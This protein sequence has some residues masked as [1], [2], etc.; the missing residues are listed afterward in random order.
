MFNCIPVLAY[1]GTFN[2]DFLPRPIIKSVL[3]SSYRIIVQNEH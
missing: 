2:A 1:S 3:V